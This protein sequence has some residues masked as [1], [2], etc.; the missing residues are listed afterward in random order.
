MCICCT[1]TG[2][3]QKVERRR[4]RRALLQLQRQVVQSQPFFWWKIR[5]LF[6][7]WRAKSWEAR[8]TAYCRRETQP[9]P[10]RLF[11]AIRKRWNFYSPTWFCLTAMA[12]TWHLN[13]P[14]AAT[15][16][17]P[18][19]SPGIRKIPSPAMDS[20]IPDGSIFPSHSQLHLCCKKLPKPC[21]RFQYRH[22][23]LLKWAVKAWKNLDARVTSSE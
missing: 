10:S 6:V 21:T 8:G 13:S 18:S 22:G 20:S 14:P 5:P 9:K 12:A 19:S 1:Q 3:G 4:T 16:S 17:K 2:W 11:T 15:P 7:T 23:S